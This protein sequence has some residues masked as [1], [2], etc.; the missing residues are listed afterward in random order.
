MCVLATQS[1]PD[2]VEGS[3]N[4]LKLEGAVTTVVGKVHNIASKRNALW[5]FMCVCV[6]VCVCVHVFG[7]FLWGSGPVRLKLWHSLVS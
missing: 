7:I 6:C 3:V 4:Y 5:S 2:G 1:C